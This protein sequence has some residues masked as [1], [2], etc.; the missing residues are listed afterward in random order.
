MTLEETSESLNEKLSDKC[1]PS[2]HWC[3]PTLIHHFSG[4]F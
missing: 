1:R 3:Q 4:I 2:N